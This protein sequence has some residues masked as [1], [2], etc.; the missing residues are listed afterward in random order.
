MRI[1]IHGINFSPETTGV[2]KYTGEMA[3]WLAQ[4]GHE[5]RVITAPPHYPQWRVTSGYRAWSYQRE[6]NAR[7]EG[8]DSPADG[9]APR[10]KYLDVVRCPVWLPEKPTGANRLLHLASFALSSFPV[11][12]GWARWRPDV[13][14]AIEPTLFCSVS[15]LLAA[16]LCGAKAWLHVQDL[17]VDAAFE[18]GDFAQ[19]SRAR[20]WALAME[21]TLLRR[22]DRVSAI[23]ARLAERLIAKGVDSSR[24]TLLPNW[25][26]PKVIYPQRSRNLYRDILGIGDCTVIALY[27]GSMGK[28]QGLEL[29]VEA[30]RQLVQHPEIQFVLCGDGP[31]RPRLVE[32]AKNLRNII[33][34]PLQPADRLNDLL[35]LAGIHLLPQRA[36]AADLVLPSKLTGMFA[37]GRPVVATAH[38]GTQLA[39]AVEGRGLV[40]PPADANR[41]ASAVLRLAEDAELRERLGRQAREYAVKYLGPDTILAEFE[42]ALLGACNRIHEPVLQDQVSGASA[43]FRSR[44]AFEG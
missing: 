15:A 37:S 41:F 16:R 4:R 24:C 38:P 39:M 32:L 19:S 31:Y 13:V 27:A 2:G 25:V 17:E 33:L 7:S 18:L 5:V 9:E 1:L 14:L 26:D 8:S 11:M 29:L 44:S 34:L 40:T 35:N 21:R 3:A 43:E 30:A 36:D 6:L 12:L 42:R 20:R 10:S 28:K 23:S 22:F